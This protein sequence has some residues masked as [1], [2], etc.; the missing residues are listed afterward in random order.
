MKEVKDIDISV[1]I[2]NAGVMYLKPFEELPLEEIKETFETNLYGL[3]ILTSL[4]VQRFL[5][6]NKRCGIV[7]VASVAGI[8]PCILMQHYSATKAYARSLTHSL[9]AELGDK[10]DIMTHSPCY[11]E[12]AMT[13]FYK[14]LDVASPRD[15]AYSIFRDIGYEVENNPTMMHEFQCFVVKTMKDFSNPLFNAVS[16]LVGKYEYENVFK[17]K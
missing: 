4:F 16:W 6:R 8:V 3:S 2:N 13:K 14:R 7:N 12:T 11:V 1:L 9:H 5:K 10:I 15:W 17:N